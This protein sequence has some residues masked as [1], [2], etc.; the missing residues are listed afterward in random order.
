MVDQLIEGINNLELNKKEVSPRQELIVKGI[1][2]GSLHMEKF[3]ANHKMH[4]KYDTKYSYKY[5]RLVSST[6]LFS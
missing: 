3:F 6:L 1:R 2:E 4:R 5:F